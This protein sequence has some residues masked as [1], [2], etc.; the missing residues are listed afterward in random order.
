MSVEDDLIQL[1]HQQRGGFSRSVEDALTNYLNQKA[2]YYK[3]TADANEE[4]AS[5]QSRLASAQDTIAAV[6]YSKNLSNYFRREK[7]GRAARLGMSVDEYDAYLRN[8][9]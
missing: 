9:F 2:S 4:A 3:R 8:A 5:A 1:L 7:E 6:E